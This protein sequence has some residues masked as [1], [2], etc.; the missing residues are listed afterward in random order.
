[1]C[2]CS[3]SA[4]DRRTR[5]SQSTPMTHIS[6]KFI[7]FRTGLIVLKMHRP[8]GSRSGADC[9][10]FSRCLMQVTGLPSGCFLVAKRHRETAPHDPHNKQECG[11]EVAALG[12]RAGG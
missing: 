9:G 11:R 4:S 6:A 10:S 8:G 1:M 5:T 7:G 2:A 12:G 3:G